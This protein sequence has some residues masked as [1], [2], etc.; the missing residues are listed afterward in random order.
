M[1]PAFTG[2]GAPHWDPAARGAIF[3]LTRDTG[4][5][6]LSRAALESV[7]YQTRDLFEAMAEDGMRPTELRVDGGMVRNDWLMQFLADILEVP[8]DRPVVNETTALGAAFLAGLRCGVY[9]SLDDLARH[10]RCEARFEPRLA[11]A[12]RTRL[13]AGWTKAVERVRESGG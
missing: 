6:E 4:P 5:A 2:L 12:E 13:V 9:G 11:A 3:G 7:C 1:V 8:V 10:W